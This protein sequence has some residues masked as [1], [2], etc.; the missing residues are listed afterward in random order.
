MQHAG[1]PVRRRAVRDVRPARYVGQAVRDRQG[2]VFRRRRFVGVRV[3][4]VRGRGAF[5]SRRRLKT[6]VVD[7]L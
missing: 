7:T 2:R 4:Y 5:N 3:R 6:D 1:L